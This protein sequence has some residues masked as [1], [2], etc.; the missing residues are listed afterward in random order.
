[1]RGKPLIEWLCFTVCWLIL[2]I[3]LIGI[4]KTKPATFPPPMGSSAVSL[5]EYWFSFESTDS[6]ER[7]EWRVGSNT[8]WQIREPG[9]FHDELIELGEY[10][11]GKPL[12]IACFWVD[13]ARRAT[14]M[15]IESTDGRQW[16]EVFWTNG[17]TLMAEPF[18][19]VPKGGVDRDG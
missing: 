16:S 8:L 9:E 14:R 18:L 12:T 3:P 11:H 5:S 17:D 6:P 19:H 15:T 13:K 1:M 4:T 2:L 10:A 7:I